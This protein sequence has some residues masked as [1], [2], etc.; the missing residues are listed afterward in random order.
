MLVHDAIATHLANLGHRM[1]QCPYASVYKLHVMRSARLAILLS[2]SVQPGFKVFLGNVQAVYM[3]FHRIGEYANLRV[4][5]VVLSRLTNV[6]CGQRR[7][8]ITPDRILELPVLA[9]IKR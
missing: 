7:F 2:K 9:D 3:L 6:L 8:K 5:F 4:H 1:L